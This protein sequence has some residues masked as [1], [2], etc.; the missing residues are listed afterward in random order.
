M[1]N[2]KGI[3]FLNI[4]RKAKMENIF[5]SDRKRVYLYVIYYNNIYYCM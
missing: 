4:G 3:L 2:I 5:F 1:I